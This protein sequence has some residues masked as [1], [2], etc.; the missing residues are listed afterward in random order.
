MVTA[1]QLEIL[2]RTVPQY[3]L[4]AGL[5][6]YLFAWIEKKNVLGLIAEVLFVVIGLLSLLTM[7]S[8]LIPSP[9]TEGV[10]G[11]IIKKVI[12]MLV[13]TLCSGG[14]ALISLIIRLIRKKGSMILVPIVFV[15][16][17]VA[18]F[19]T[20]DMSRVHFQLNVPEATETIPEEKSEE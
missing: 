17:V 6:L 14:L 15:I 4:F 11:E 8:G 9:L 7:L 10:D 3:F 16:S 5:A 12:K 19:Q 1:D 2:L 13:I 20:T 18:F